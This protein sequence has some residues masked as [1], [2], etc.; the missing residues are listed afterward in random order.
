MPRTRRQIALLALVAI[1][2]MHSMNVYAES[3]VDEAVQKVEEAIED[4]PVVVDE[5][6]SEEPSVVEPETTEEVSEPV[7]VEEEKVEE[8]LSQV[9]EEEETADV[10]EAVEEV[11]NEVVSKVTDFL[12]SKNI[13]AKKIA[14][15]SLGA[16]GT[17]TGIGWA[18]DKI[19]GGKDE[20]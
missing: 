1:T 5:P 19:G 20:A 14:A 11:K 8:P 16:W 7:A 4:A 18:M 6:A 13:D 15:F 3:A 2:S 10:A 9:V 17:A 12:Q